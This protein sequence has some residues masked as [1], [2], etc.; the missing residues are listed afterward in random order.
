MAGQHRRQDHSPEVSGE[1]SRNV[2]DVTLRPRG[3]FTLMQRLI[4]GKTDKRNK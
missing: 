2:R 1:W 4:L 3:W